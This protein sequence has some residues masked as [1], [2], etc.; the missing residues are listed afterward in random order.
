MDKS[1]FNLLLND[2]KEFVNLSKK[3]F[4]TK[5]YMLMIDNI[6]KQSEN[7]IAKVFIAGSQSSDIS[8]LINSVIDM[9]L[10][11]RSEKIPYIVEAQYSQNFSICI[12]TEK[13]K[14]FFKKIEHFNEIYADTKI[15][16]KKIV[17]CVNN[18]VLETATIVFC[19]LD[20]HD[21]SSIFLREASK[22][23]FYVLAVDAVSTVL[24]PES[25][26]INWIKTSLGSTKN[27]SVVINGVDKAFTTDETIYML[28]T[29]YF[30]DTYFKIIETITDKKFRDDDRYVKNSF[31]NLIKAIDY[32]K[33]QE[34]SSLMLKNLIKNS[35]TPIEDRL[36]LKK[37]ERDS[38]IKELKDY[39]DLCKEFFAYTNIGKLRTGFILSDKQKNILY[40]DMGK[41]TVVIQQNL[42]EEI[43]S[44]ESKEYVAAF[45]R[46]Y[47]NYLWE[48]F[49]LLETEIIKQGIYDEFLKLGSWIK[50]IYAK[51]F[52]EE[53]PSDI[54]KLLDVN[55][56]KM[57]KNDMVF[58]GDFEGQERIIA[59]AISTII[60]S[61]IGF[62][63]LFQYDKLKSAISKFIASFITKKQF[64]RNVVKKL[65][66]SLDMQL[67]ELKKIYSLNIFAIV[68][69]EL[70]NGFDLYI[71][72]LKACLNKQR[73]EKGEKIRMSKQDIDDLDALLTRNKLLLG[74]FN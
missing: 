17:I 22:C 43:G 55:L 70:K 16:I 51:I 60:I 18:S 6:K 48:Q 39:E 29:V 21:N 46:D 9:G 64:D 35:Q 30:E 68:D 1:E 19:T 7:S 33:N 37:D 54:S 12:F 10:Y 71:Q 34:K 36:K 32:S 57:M 73:D 45:V 27:L 8:S 58:T 72:E 13:E 47:V 15:E 56:D 41:F 23:D 25:Q 2:A 50:A 28:E 3:Y 42:L 61:I 69:D 59:E 14:L 40:D 62:R 44:I 49:L 52:D 65:N 38:L 11:E 63:L 26:Y 20:D 74:R 4:D 66:E 31:I 5:E 67:S 24:Y 53:V